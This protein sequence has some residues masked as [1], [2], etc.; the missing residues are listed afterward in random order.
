VVTEP[1]AYGGM[2]PG[3]IAF[4]GQHETDAGLLKQGDGGVLG[5]GRVQREHR[6]EGVP[7]SAQIVQKRSDFPDNR[8]SATG[9]LG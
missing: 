5:L 6:V 4:D 7:D 9:G 1:V 8:R 2:Q 3:L